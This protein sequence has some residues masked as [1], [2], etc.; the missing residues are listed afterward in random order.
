M[1]I[2]I[3]DG[4]WEA[5]YTFGG[6]NAAEP[7]G[8]RGNAQDFVELVVGCIAALQRRLLL[9]MGIESEV[10]LSKTPGSLDTLEKQSLSRTISRISL[11]S[12][13]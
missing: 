3:P 6:Y 4:R 13:S 12:I 8:D 9:F 2:R 10:E 5:L 1:S 11:M 7:L